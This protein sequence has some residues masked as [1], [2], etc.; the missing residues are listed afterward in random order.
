MVGVLFGNIQPDLG[1]LR[2]KAVH[3]ERFNTAGQAGSEIL[4]AP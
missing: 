1:I 4:A 2:V 3:V